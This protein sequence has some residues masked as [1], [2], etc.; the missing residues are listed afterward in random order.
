[1]SYLLLYKVTGL[2]LHKTCC[3]TICQ[4]LSRT[5]RLCETK[6]QNFRGTSHFCLS[7]NESNFI[8]RVKIQA[9]N[10][11][12]L[13]VWLSALNNIPPEPG[14]AVRQIPLFTSTA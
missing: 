10:V 1:M 7:K 12:W 3:E 4:R 2:T 5:S 11:G 14:H 9:E 6:W 8:F 13:A